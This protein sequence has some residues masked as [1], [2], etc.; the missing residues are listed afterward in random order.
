[1]TDVNP[2]SPLDATHEPPRPSLPTS[3]ECDFCRRTIASTETYHRVTVG[4]NEDGESSAHHPITVEEVSELVACVACQP[5]VSAVL[6]GFLDRLWTMRRDS[7]PIGEMSSDDLPPSEPTVPAFSLPAVEFPFNLVSA[8]AQRHVDQML[9]LAAQAFPPSPESFT[10]GVAVGRFV[11]AGLDPADIH[12]L[13]DNALGTI[14][15]QSPESLP[16]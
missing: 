2:P 11:A 10:L 12:T 1:M 14:A 9:E 3:E 13:V 7:Q 4:M 5:A 15:N 6:D 16:S 8:D